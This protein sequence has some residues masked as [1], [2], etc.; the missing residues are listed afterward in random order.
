MNFCDAP[1]DH[2][3]RR[4][5]PVLQL[6]IAN[7]ILSLLVSFFVS[8]GWL[9]NFTNAGPEFVA[10]F[11]DGNARTKNPAVRIECGLRS[12]ST[13]SRASTLHHHF[14]AFSLQPYR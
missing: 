3:V 9:R 5:Q 6:L 4:F 11:L 8:A 14:N 1:D 2:E 7:L 10:Q 13:S 12:L